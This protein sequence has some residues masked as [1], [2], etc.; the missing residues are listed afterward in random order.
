MVANFYTKSI[1]IIHPTVLSDGIEARNISK[2]QSFRRSVRSSVRRRASV[3]AANEE[4]KKIAASL[5][6]ELGISEPKTSRQ[7]NRRTN[8]ADASVFLDSTGPVVGKGVTP[9]QRGHVSHLLFAETHIS[10]MLLLN[11]TH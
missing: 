4:R 2:T 8:S 10:S 7:L 5:N 3:V 6:L 9:E 11:H 1:V